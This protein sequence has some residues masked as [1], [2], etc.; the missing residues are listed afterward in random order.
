MRNA[1]GHQG[2][3]ERQQKKSEQEHIQYFLHQLCMQTAAFWTGLAIRCPFTS[4]KLCETW[5]LNF[6]TVMSY[7]YFLKSVIRA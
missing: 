5:T 7:F 2:K 3:N 6:I 4:E 1:S